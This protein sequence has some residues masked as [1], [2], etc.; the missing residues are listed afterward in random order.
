MSDIYAASPVVR[1]YREERRDCEARHRRRRAAALGRE[2]PAGRA[3]SNVPRRC[4]CAC[5]KPIWTES[6]A[7]SLSRRLLQRK[8][9]VLP[10]R[11]KLV[12][13]AT[14]D[15]LKQRGTARFDL[16]LAGSFCHSLIDAVHVA[17]SQHRPLTLSPDDIW[18]VI[19]QG[20]GHH[21]A[22]NAEALRPR[23]VRHQGKCDLSAIVDDLSLASFEQA[24]T[25]F[26]SQIMDATDPVL[27][28]TLVCDFSTTTPAIRTASEVAL[29]DSFSSYFNFALYCVCGIPKITIE[30]SLD[31][32]RRIRARVEV[33]ETYGLEWWV[34]RL[35]PILDEFVLAAGG[36]PTPEF[37]KAIYK[38][39]KAYGGEA[40]T[41]WI[42]DLFPYLG[43]APHR[44]RSH[45]FEHD[46]HDWAL[47]VKTGVA[48]NSF[49]T[50]LSGV[51][52]KVRFTDGSSRDV[53]FVAG[54]FAVRHNP[55][56][57][58]LAPVIGW[59]VAEPPPPRPMRNRIG[60]IS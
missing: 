17:F 59:C 60:A 39:E 29:M 4:R 25:S 14:V 12:T 32:W 27:H 54:F 48:S 23:L 1:A 53:D 57:L 50:G 6:L 26:S 7:D 15:F 45:V 9:L 2:A 16:A 42:A 58:A 3:W 56:D 11:E 51:P 40:A 5:E 10:E 20:F 8:I 36:H 52:V 37:W 19:A 18:L 28:E 44:R 49:P 46:R 41:G 31:D 43:D 13:N 38:P 34:S 33:L 35:R 47:P 22:E 21:V 55:P 30:G 24:I